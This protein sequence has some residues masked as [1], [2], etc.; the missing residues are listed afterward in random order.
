VLELC[1]K[2]LGVAK[3]DPPL[4]LSKLSK[5]DPLEPE[6]WLPVDPLVP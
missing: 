3:W 1:L 2:C 5:G 6:L 4:G